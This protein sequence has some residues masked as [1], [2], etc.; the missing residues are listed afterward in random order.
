MAAKRSSLLLKT[1]F[2]LDIYIMVFVPFHHP[3]CCMNCTVVVLEDEI[4]IGIN[5]LHRKQHDVF[6]NP[7][8]NIAS[9]PLFPMDHYHTAP[10]ELL[11]CDHRASPNTTWIHR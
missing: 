7:N 11:A 8:V 2:G 4:P 1:T 10:I 3:A 5:S 6:E 9:Q